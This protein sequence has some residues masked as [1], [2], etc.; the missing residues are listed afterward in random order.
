MDRVRLGAGVPEN[1][2]AQAARRHRYF[3]TTHVPMIWDAV[4]AVLAGTLAVGT[5][6]L[7]WAGAI[8][9]RLREH[10]TRLNDIERRQSGDA[11]NPN[12]PGVLQKV[13]DLERDLEQVNAKLNQARRER[14]QE[15]EHVLERLDDLESELRDR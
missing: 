4:N 3:D 15:H 6:I 7:G 10:A 11:N 8:E 9:K 12:S 13:A 1:G 2:A 5:A 14:K